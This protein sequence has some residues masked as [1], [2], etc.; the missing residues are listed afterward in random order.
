MNRL[1]GEGEYYWPNGDL[2][3]GEFLNNKR[4]GKG[5]LKLV[6]GVTYSG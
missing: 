5:I 3:K 1:N 6:D 2:Y 4:H